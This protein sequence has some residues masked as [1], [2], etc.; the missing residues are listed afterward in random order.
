MNIKP[1]ILPTLMLAGAATLLLAPEIAAAG[2]TTSATGTND[3]SGLSS[4]VTDQVSSLK[5]L[6]INVAFIA[7]FGFLLAGV[8]KFKAHRDN[9]TQVPLSAPIVLVVVGCVLIYLPNLADVG[10][11]SVFGA[12]AK[13]GVGGTTSTPAGS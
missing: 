12:D 8:V 7:G 9:P 11:A 4:R 13:Q 3:L 6:I 1:Y 2:G 5:D 10:G